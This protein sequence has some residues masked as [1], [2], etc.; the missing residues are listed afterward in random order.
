LPWR[1]HDPARV[2]HVAQAVA[3]EIDRQPVGG[4]AGDPIK[5]VGRPGSLC[6]YVDAPGRGPE[7]AAS[8]VTV[9][10]TTNR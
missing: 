4:V 9:T 3:D 5:W 8:F 7:G 6:L 1:S 2:E 10:V